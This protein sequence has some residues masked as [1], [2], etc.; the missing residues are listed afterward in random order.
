MFRLA[1]PHPRR[2]ACAPRPLFAAFRLLSS[3]G[4]SV[5]ARRG[6]VHPFA[7]LASQR[8]TRPMKLLAGSFAAL[9]LSLS[10][11]AAD[12]T[13]TQLEIVPQFG[14]PNMF[15]GE[16]EHV[17]VMFSNE[18]PNDDNPDAF[19]EPPVYLADRVSGNDCR[20]EDGGIWSRGGVF[21]SQDGRRVLMHEFSG[22]SAE[23]VSYDSATCKVVHREDISGQRWAVDKDGLRLGQKCS[24]ESV[25]SCAK[26]VK[27]SLAPFC[28]TAKK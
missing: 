27:R 19:P 4:A 9:F 10:A 15:G 18:D 22:S 8:R 20:I 12:C 17:R 13:F 11:Q 1:A 25:D 16:D 3:G 24:G 5:R 21:L 2:F 26:V 28:Q 14:S 6:L 23:L 7:A